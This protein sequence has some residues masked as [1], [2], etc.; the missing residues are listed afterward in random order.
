MDQNEKAAL[1]AFGSLLLLM[2]VKWTILIGINRK[3][4]KF[5]DNAKIRRT[6][7]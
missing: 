5:R 7:Y 4:K 6:Y 3:A 1:N 2:T